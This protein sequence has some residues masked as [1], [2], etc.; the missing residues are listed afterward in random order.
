MPWHP[1]VDN[2]VLVDVA[3]IDAAIISI[4]SLHPVRV[5]PVPR[6]ANPHDCAQK[7]CNHFPSKQKKKKK[8]HTKPKNQNQTTHISHVFSTPFN[9]R[10]Q[11]RWHRDILN[12]SSYLNIWTFIFCAHLIRERIFDWAAQLG[13]RRVVRMKRVRRREQLLRYTD[14]QPT[15]TSKTQK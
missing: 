6:A 14:S 10:W 2:C 5:L 7:H 11:Q 13:R 8:T 4:S 3:D 15:A 1:F 9:L 12:R